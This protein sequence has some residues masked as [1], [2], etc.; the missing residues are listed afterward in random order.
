MLIENFIWDL[1]RY[2]N[3]NT[4]SEEEKTFV[5]S[6]FVAGHAKTFY[7]EYVEKFSMLVLEVPRMDEEDKFHYFMEGL[8]TWAQNEI[9]RQGAHDIEEQ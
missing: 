6:L 5:R 2:F 1:Q 9:H 4:T 7:R 3:A 8:Q